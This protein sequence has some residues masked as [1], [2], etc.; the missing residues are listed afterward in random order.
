MLASVA[1]SFVTLHPTLNVFTAFGIDQARPLWS[2]LETIHTIFHDG[3]GPGEIL[4]T[5]ARKILEEV[6]GEMQKLELELI[7]LQGV[8][9]GTGFSHID[10]LKKKIGDII[11]E[12]DAF[13]EETLK[14]FRYNY[15]LFAKVPLSNG[16]I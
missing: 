12:M 3:I 10:E 6:I 4:P 14:P 13:N 5:Q 15:R 1:D 16:S 8:L 7:F 11:G 9:E 2:R